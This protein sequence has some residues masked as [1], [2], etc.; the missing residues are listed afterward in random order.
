MYK[1]VKGSAVKA[2]TQAIN[3]L[4]AVLV[5]A[6]PKLGEELAGLNNAELF[7]TCAGLADNGKNGEDGEEAVLQA[8]RITLCLLANRPAHG[9][10]PGFGRPHPSGGGVAFG[11]V[12]GDRVDAGACVPLQGADGGVAGAGRQHRGGRA[13]LGVVCRGAVAD[14][15]Q[16]PAVAR[17]SM[18]VP[19]TA[20]A[21]SAP[22]RSCRAR[23]RVRWSA[24]AT[25][26]ATGPR[27]AFLLGIAAPCARQNRARDNLEEAVGAWRERVLIAEPSEHGHQRE[28]IGAIDIA[29]RHARGLGTGEEPRTGRAQGD[30]RSVE[31][32]LGVLDGGCHQH[33]H[34]PILGCPRDAVA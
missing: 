30:A 2:R 26:S 10:D 25:I 4:K 20:L 11:D 9:T 28:Q 14:P 5:S 15:V 21:N 17:G 32:G 34:A 22:N 16:C 12:P 1:L 27:A 19:L 3:Q 8:T 33:G 23:G 18:P 24:C 31:C 6:D 13:V 7:R 29:P